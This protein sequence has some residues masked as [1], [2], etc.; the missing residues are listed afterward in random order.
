MRIE[1]D[2]ASILMDNQADPEMIEALQHLGVSCTNDLLVLLDDPDDERAARACWLLG[3]LRK[4]RFSRALLNTL[5]S[6]RS[7]LWIPS[8]V[9]LTLVESKRPTRRLIE[10]TLDL[11]LP[12][13]QR[14]AAAYTLAFTTTA[15]QDMRWNGVIADTFMTVLGN[16]EE[17]PHLRGVVAEGLGNM[18]SGCFGNGDRSGS[19]YNNA[20]NLLIVTLRDPAPEVRFWFAFALGA[21]RFHSAVPALRVLANTDNGYFGDWWTI[22]EEASDAIDRIEGREPPDRTPRNACS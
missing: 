10:V 12:A 13:D 20:G 2:M 22:G 21:I 16:N 3:R 7:A 17:P 5:C 6:D 11:R 14:Y 18:F 19:V 4:K 15:L 1:S 9:A 8:A